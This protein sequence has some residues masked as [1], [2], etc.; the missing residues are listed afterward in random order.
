MYQ[1]ILVPVDGSPTAEQGLDEAIKLARLTGGQLRLLYVV[2]ELMFVT[3]IQEYSAYSADLARLMKDAG[4][5]ILRKAAER[6]QAAGAQVDTLLVESVSGRVSDVIVEQATQ[7][8]AEVIVLGTHGRRGLRRIALGSDA[9]QV[10][11]AATVPVL[12]V[13]GRD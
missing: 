5:D 8:R 7:W 2:D 4:T 3:S 13:R 6:A 1:R 10:V 9:E 12:L 11:R